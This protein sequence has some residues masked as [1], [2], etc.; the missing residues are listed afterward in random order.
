MLE[1]ERKFLVDTSKLPGCMKSTH[2]VQ[3][4]L[5][6]D[7]DRTVRVRI[8]GDKAYLTI[9][10][11]RSG[12]G[13]SCFEWEKEI[14]FFE[15][16]NL[17]L[18]CPKTLVKDRYHAVVAGKTWEIDVFRGFHEGLVVAEIELA[19]EDDEFV[20]PQWVT[21]EVTG[22]SQYYNSQLLKCE[23]RWW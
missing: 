1:I 2:I 5:S 8:S 17:M 9:K 7:K 3:G 6:D 22:F 11:G 15:A 4:Y 13:L 20:R 18:L 14:G 23:R 21:A 12:S 10:G 19:S 16:V